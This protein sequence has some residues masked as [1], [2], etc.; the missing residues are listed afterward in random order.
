MVHWGMR[1]EDSHV[2]GEAVSSLFSSVSAQCWNRTGA[3]ALAACQAELHSSIFVFYLVRCSVLD[4]L[5]FVRLF[6]ATV[7]S[8]RVVRSDM[9]FFF[10]PVF[11]LY[12]KS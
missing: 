9:S 8:R 1:R 6:T 7:A 11:F 4:N 3:I 2:F 10:T 5:N 12:F